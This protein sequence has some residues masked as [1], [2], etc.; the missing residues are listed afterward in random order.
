MLVS[1]FIWWY[2]FQFVKLKKNVCVFHIF[3]NNCYEWVS[4]IETQHN[5]STIFIYEL[6]RNMYA[7]DIYMFGHGSAK[8]TLFQ[9]TGGGAKGIASGVHI[10][11]CLIILSRAF[12]RDSPDMGVMLV[13]VIYDLFLQLLPLHHVFI[14]H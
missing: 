6:D 14:R 11:A 2:Y 9:K 12:E 8:D 3:V 13:V 4:I 5:K 1:I 10:S 7:A